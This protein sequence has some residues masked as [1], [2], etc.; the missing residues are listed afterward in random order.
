MSGES[1]REGVIT[2]ADTCREFV[3]PCLVEAGWGAAPH[4]IGEQRSLTNRRIIVAG[5]KV[6]RGK[7][8]R[9]DYGE[10]GPQ[11]WGVNFAAKRAAAVEAARYAAI[12]LGKPIRELEQSIQAA[13]NDSNPGLQEQ[14][15]ALKAEQQAHEQ[16]AK[17]AQAEGDNLYWPI[18]NLDIKNPKGK[19]GLEH[20]DPKDLIAAMRSH[21][22]EIM[23]LLGEI[24]AMVAE[25]QA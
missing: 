18:Y 4:V 13:T 10:E 1:M 20:A 2:E 14:L 24:E 25:V 15:R 17:V 22:A 11:T 6:R 19:V 12:A 21:E 16:T 7:Q 3:T 8:K 23:R 9:A 5:G